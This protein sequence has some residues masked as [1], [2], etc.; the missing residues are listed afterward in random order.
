MPRLNRPTQRDLPTE[1][2]AYSSQLKFI[3]LH[4]LITLGRTPKP[5][6][7]EENGG[8]DG[9]SAMAA[10]LGVCIKAIPPFGLGRSEHQLGP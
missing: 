1:G 5:W 8:V 3:H 4:L 7:M 2:A 9:T 10:C 6:I